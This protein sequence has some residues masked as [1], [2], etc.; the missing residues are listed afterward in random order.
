MEEF[1]KA[2]ERLIVEV[3]LETNFKQLNIDENSWNNKIA[4]IAVAA[5]EDQCSPANPRVPM[6][7]DMKAMLKKVY[8]K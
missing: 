4:S 7:E 1:A 6:V 8:D 2:V 5:Y 3:G